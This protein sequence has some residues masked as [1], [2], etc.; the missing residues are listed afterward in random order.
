M[1]PLV[2]LAAG[3]L[4]PVLVEETPL[5]QGE[6][7]GKQGQAALIQG[8]RL[9]C[10]CEKGGGFDR[11]RQRGAALRPAAQSSCAFSSNLV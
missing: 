3:A 4:A 9:R 10:D 2:C 6:E 1:G 11:A 5:I 7:E 8:D